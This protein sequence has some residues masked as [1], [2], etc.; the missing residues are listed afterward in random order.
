[1]LNYLSKFWRHIGGGDGGGVG[2]VYG[3][4]CDFD[5]V[6]RW[7]WWWRTLVLCFKT[8]SACRLYNFEW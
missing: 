2:G 6:G 4:G 3:G 7:R 8:Q 1:M 5:E